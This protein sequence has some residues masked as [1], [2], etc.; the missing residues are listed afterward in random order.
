MK[1][2]MTTDTVGGVWT[3]TLNLCDALRNHGISIEL[4]S[5]GRRLS[6]EQN[7]QL[8]KLPHVRLHESSFRLCWMQ[9]A[10]SDVAAAGNW[11]KELEQGLQPD[12]VHLNDLAH[13]SLPWQAPVLLVGHS[14]VY[15][16]HQAV[17]G[18]PPDESWQRYYQAVR[19]SIAAADLLVAPSRAML[20]SLRANY[21]VAPPGQVI[22]NGAPPSTRQCLETILAKEPF[23]LAAGRLWDEA[24][25]VGALTAIATDLRW[26][27]YLAGEAGHHQAQPKN[28]QHLGF[29]E[30]QELR[31][32]MQRAGIYAAPAYYEPFGLGILE[33][34]QAG[35]ALVLG[36]IPSLREL[37]QGAAIF[38]E[39][40]DPAELCR[41]INHLT[42]EDQLRR[43][44]AQQ[45]W[46]RAQSFSTERM[47]QAYLDCYRS[48]LTSRPR[49]RGTAT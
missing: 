47:A 43:Q 19:A 33:A 1:V 26:P 41:Q 29:L 32:W 37:W 18:T 24:K 38:V 40:D 14:C 16:W 2:L 9:D 35:C 13:G 6:P 17:K 10:W 31:K 34:A 39:P 27:L 48:L 5:M 11:L 44:L 25:N 23:I 42:D 8:S 36:D 22:H 4:A 28:V 15:S 49:L 30:H 45:A 46:Q 12:L 21:E 3:Y 7:R 20:D